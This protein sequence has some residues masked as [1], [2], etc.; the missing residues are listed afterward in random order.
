MPEVTDADMAVMEH[1]IGEIAP[2]SFWKQCISPSPPPPPFPPFPNPSTNPTHRKNLFL[3]TLSQFCYVGAQV[4]VANYFIKFAEQVGRSA[5]NSS[6][7][8]SAAQ[9]I[10]AGMRFI[11][12]F[13]MM[14]PLVKPRL[15]LLTFLALCFAFAIA[16]MNT[17]GS[18][19]IGLLMIV[20]AFESAC[21]ATIFTLSLRGLGRHTKLGGSLQVAALSGG[22]VFSPIM[23]A[24]VDSR[25]AHFAMLVPALGYAVAWTFPVYVNFGIGGLWVAIGRRWLML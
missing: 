20:F 2:G 13:L 21:F 25:G 9:G 6:A 4:A 3:G 22:M 12:G 14:S 18:L 7:L 17:S 19:P 10:Y 16:A 24:V 8:L 11:S 23:G 15:I 1:E 5:S